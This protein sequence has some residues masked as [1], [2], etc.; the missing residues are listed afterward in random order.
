MLNSLLQSLN[1]IFEAGIAITALSLF[2]RALTF[3]LRDRVSR[4]FAVL[5]A[6]VMIVF[7][8]EAISGAVLV[9][10]IHENWLKLQWVGIIFFP[11]ALIHFSDAL[12]ETTGQ[13]SRGR[14]SKLV[15]IS[16]IISLSFLLTLIFGYLTGPV[17]YAGPVPHLTRTSLSTFFIVIYLVAVIFSIWSIWRA[18]KRTKIKVSQRRMWYLMSGVLF[19][20]LGTYP[21]LQIGSAFAYNSPLLF[22]SLAT[23][24]NIAVFVF[25]LMMAYSVA[26]FGIPW[27]DRLVRSRLLKWFLRGPATVFMVLIIITAAREFGDFYNSDYS[28]SIPIFTAITVLLM[29]HM[30]TLV[31]P[32]LERSI[33]NIGDQGNIQLLQTI[34]ERLIT[35]GDLKQF[36]EAVLASACDQFQVSTA[37]IAALD[38]HGIEH[39][40]QVGEK[41]SLEKIGF[42]STLLELASKNNNGNNPVF[43]WG[44][45]WLYP[46]YSPENNTLLGLLGVIRDETIDLNENQKEAIK[47][48]GERAA[49]ALE[50]RK[51]QQQIFSA[52]QE[53]EPKVNMIQRLRAAARF[54][55]GEILKDLDQLAEQ[56][57]INQL[58]KDALSHY[59]G[60]PKLSESPLISLQVVQEAL[61]D[62]DGNP[63]NALRSTLKEAISRVRPV[64]VRR[65]TAEWILFNILEMKFMEGRKVREIALRLAMSEA[66]LYR[67][68][69]VAIEEV[70]KVFLEMEV[71]ARSDE[72]AD[73]S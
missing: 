66:D 52:L 24:G 36:L 40:V 65:F 6:C 28:V 29:E 58:I 5:L 35:T 54:D 69:R 68:Q 41:K 45:F 25:L 7:S 70:S 57:N 50:D 67:K 23:I 55:Q 56:K 16:Y 12:L 43:E 71:N 30:I 19:L 4:S 37:F 3:N 22:I 13:P 63:V 15:I 62:N 31:F 72:D 61:K 53:L 20:S 38:N 11:A 21:Y 39:V 42:D 14:R 73:I 51:V 46:L 27:P 49:L 33:F 48:L 64:G 10:N 2:F 44:E 32:A 8:G 59:W 17:T 47:I 18:Y 9:E 26:F 1:Q 34:S 60:G